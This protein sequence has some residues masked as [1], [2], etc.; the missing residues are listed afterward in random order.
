MEKVQRNISIKSKGK[1][2]Q[3][4]HA[5]LATQRHRDSSQGILYISSGLPGAGKSTFLKNYK[6][7]NEVIVS[8]DEIRFSMR[9]NEKEE[10]FA[11]EK[12]V[13]NTF[14][15][16]IIKNLKTGNNVYA[17]AT[18]LTPQSQIKLLNAVLQKAAPSRIELI[19]FDVP[20]IT[21]LQRNEKRKNTKAFVPPI[22]ICKMAKSINL[23]PCVYIDQTWRIDEDG[24]VSK[25]Q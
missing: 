22:I 17:D 1:I 14:I 7:Q 5:D 19:C 16:E 4:N 3:K 10:Y 20:L 2:M 13:Y 8:R 9:R 12:K 15:Q 21:C 23:S 18:H 6:K 11:H 24:N 25:E